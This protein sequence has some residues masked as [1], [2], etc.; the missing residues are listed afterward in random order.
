MAGLKRR[1]VN[2]R[3]M[4]RESRRLLSID[5]PM[6]TL[7][8]M[9]DYNGFPTTVTYRALGCSR[10]P[11]PRRNTCRPLDYAGQLRPGIYIFTGG[12]TQGLNMSDSTVWQ[13]IFI[14]A[15]DN[16]LKV[17][18]S[19]FGN[20]DSPSQESVH[21]HDFNKHLT[22]FRAEWDPKR[23][24]GSIR[25]PCSSKLKIVLECPCIPLIS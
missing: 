15:Q 5:C 18:N 2:E 3:G 25:V 19:F 17:L 13:K 22:P 8:S 6:K 14:T 11:A 1:Y 4:K 20:L 7:L 23:I 16:C 10:L 24:A 9:P 21:S 12:V